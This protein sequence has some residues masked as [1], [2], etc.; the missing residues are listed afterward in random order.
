[1]WLVVLIK[2]YF[3]MIAKRKIIT[4]KQI[5][6]IGTTQENIVCLI[7]HSNYTSIVFVSNNPLLMAYNLAVYDQILPSFFVRVKRGCT[8]NI[9]FI[10]EL[11]YHDRSII[12]VNNQ[13]IPIARRR[14][15]NIKNCLRKYDDGPLPRGN[16]A[17]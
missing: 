4:K 9:R 10:K 2:N 7:A 3:G 12:L 1:M 16:K 15:E 5:N 13:E 8:I 17:I 6:L 14:R 11:N